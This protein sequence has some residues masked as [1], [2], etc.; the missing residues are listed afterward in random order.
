MFNEIKIKLDFNLI[1]LS[2]KIA[3]IFARKIKIRYARID[4]FNHSVHLNKMRNK[5]FNLL[6]ARARNKIPVQKNS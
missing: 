2:S 1:P 5:K 4:A 3:Y 6:V